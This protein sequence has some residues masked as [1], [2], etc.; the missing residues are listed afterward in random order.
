[1]SKDYISF[2]QFRNWVHCPYYHKVVYIDKLYRFPGN[3]HTSFGTAIH[4]TY[5]KSIVTEEKFDKALHFNKKYL[6]L[7]KELSGKGVKFNKKLV[8]DMRE[9]GAELAPLAIPALKEYFGEYEIFSVEEEIYETIHEFPKKE[10]KFKG[11]ID[12][13]LK[14]KDGKYHIIDWKTCSWGWNSQ[15]RSDPIINYQ[16]VFYK[17]FFAKKYDIDPKKIEI[18]FALAKRTKPGPRSKNKERIEIFRTTS[19]AKKTDNALN[20]LIKAL[21]NMVNGVSIKNRLSCNRCDIYKTK[22]CK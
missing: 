17:H 9:Q 11:F 20:Y 6:E 5:E 13:V 16:L 1:M 15:K 19:G 18:Y 12:L 2:S 4:N 7:L 14:T 21:H 22:F 8:E 10:F 3:E